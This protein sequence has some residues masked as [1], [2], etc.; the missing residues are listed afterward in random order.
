MQIVFALEAV[1]GGWFA[2]EA[3]G[4]WFEEDI[5]TVEGGAAVGG[6]SSSVGINS[7]IGISL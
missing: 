7:S 4:G 2:P 5:L 1:P 3:A 6:G